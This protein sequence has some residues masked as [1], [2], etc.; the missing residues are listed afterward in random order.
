VFFGV[1]ALPVLT[2]EHSSVRH[3]EQFTAD[4]LEPR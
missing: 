4:P 2:I 1:A 3:S